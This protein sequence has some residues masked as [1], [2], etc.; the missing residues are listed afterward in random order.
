M[1]EPAATSFHPPSMLFQ[2]TLERANGPI[3]AEHVAYV[4]MLATSDDLVDAQQEQAEQDFLLLLLIN[5][6]RHKK[7]QAR[8]FGNIYELLK[9][10]ATAA[11]EPILK[12]SD[13]WKASG[14]DRSRQLALASVRDRLLQV[15]LADDP[16]FV[17]K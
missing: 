13:F 7:P 15:L 12:F 1:S 10:D 5:E 8:S 9:A 17:D 3:D 4:I 14:S 6:I 11:V 16:D 2:K